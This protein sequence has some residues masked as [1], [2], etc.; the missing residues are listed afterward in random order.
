MNEN[1]FVNLL[2]FSS[3][4][5]TFK[6]DTTAATVKNRTFYRDNKS[7]NNQHIAIKNF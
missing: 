1:N 2:Q 4:K 6:N 7:L 5:S 3:Q